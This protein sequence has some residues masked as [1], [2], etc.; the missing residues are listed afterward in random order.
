MFSTAVK[1]LK[2]KRNITYI[3]FKD[4]RSYSNA[5]VFFDGKGLNFYRDII[6][7]SIYIKSE[8]LTKIDLNEINTNNVKRMFS[9]T[10]K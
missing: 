2:T 4:Y 9:Y 10:E 6:T 7:D 3:S 5:C 1:K 8:E